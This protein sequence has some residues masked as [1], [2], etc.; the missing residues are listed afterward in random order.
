M[1]QLNTMP[2]GSG[3]YVREARQWLYK[4]DYPRRIDQFI[5][6]FGTGAVSRE[7]LPDACGELVLEFPA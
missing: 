5:D 1:G 2:I 3:P 4:A 6:F 7:A